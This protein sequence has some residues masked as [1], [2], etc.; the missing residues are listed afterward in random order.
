M[1]NTLGGWF[2]V[3]QMDIGGRWLWSNITSRVFIAQRVNF[4]R[5]NFSIHT[6]DYLPRIPSRSPISLPGRPQPSGTSIRFWAQNH[7]ESG[8]HIRLPYRFYIDHVAFPYHPPMFPSHLQ[9]LFSVYMVR[10]PKFSI[11]FWI[12]IIKIQLVKHTGGNGISRVPRPCNI[13]E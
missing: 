7:R 5:I 9:H 4:T 1:V 3:I 10:K 6:F 13:I 12:Q 11:R 8:F 2:G